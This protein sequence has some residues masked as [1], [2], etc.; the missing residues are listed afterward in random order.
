MKLYAITIRGYKYYF[1]G[2]LSHDEC[3]KINRFCTEMTSISQSINPE[4]I[5]QKTIMYISTEIG[6]EI[7]PARIGYIFRID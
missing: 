1:F 7:S 2:D 4:D 6:V 5:Y 3:L